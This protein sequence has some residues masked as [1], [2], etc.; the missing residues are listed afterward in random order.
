MLMDP[1]APAVIER[2]D[3]VKMTLANV[4]I[5]GI[6]QAAASAYVIVESGVPFPVGS[7]VALR[8]AG[9]LL[10]GTVDDCAPQGDSFVIGVDLSRET[11][12]A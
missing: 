6:V 8:W 10:P 4:E 9:C 5:S 2:D 1:S 11:P 7:E 12:A 3:L